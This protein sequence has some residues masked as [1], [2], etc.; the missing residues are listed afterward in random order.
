YE[1][2]TNGDSL[3]E[4]DS[5]YYVLTVNVGVQSYYDTNHNV[6]SD[7]GKIVVTKTS[8]VKYDETGAE[9]A[10]LSADAQIPFVNEDKEFTTTLPISANKTLVLAD[11][12][13]PVSTESSNLLGGMTF[14]F[15]FEEVNASSDSE[16]VTAAMNSSTKQMSVLYTNQTTATPGISHI[17]GTSNLDGTI[18]FAGEPF[19]SSADEF[20]TL[21]A[22][23]SNTH[24]Y[25][26]SERDNEYSA[27]DKDTNF[28]LVKVTDAMTTDTNGDPVLEASVDSI[29]K[30]SSTGTSLGTVSSMNEI[31]FV[32][33]MEDVE[34]SLNAT[35]HIIDESISR[36]KFSFYVF[37]E[38]A[39]T[40]DDFES[41]AKDLT[42]LNGN[43]T[44]CSTVTIDFSADNATEYL[45]KDK[46]A[47]LL[48]GKSL[49]VG[50]YDYYVWEDTTSSAGEDVISSVKTYAEDHT[51]YACTSD[52]EYISHIIWDYSYYNIHYSVVYDET[53]NK[54]VATP[55]ITKY[56]YGTDAFN[57]GTVVSTVEFTNNYIPKSGKSTVNYVIEKSL[58]QDGNTITNPDFT[59][60][61][62]DVTSIY[63]AGD[64]SAVASYTAYT[65]GGDQVTTKLS[66]GGAF[67]TLTYSPKDELEADDKNST[68]TYYYKIGEIAQDGFTLSK[69]TFYV[70]AVT[71][72][73]DTTYNPVDQES[74]QTE[75]VRRSASVIR[76][77]QTIT[78]YT[79]DDQGTWTNEDVTSSLNSITTEL[80]EDSEHAD[81]VTGVALTLD[82]LNFHNTSDEVSLNLH[83]RKYLDGL[84]EGTQLSY[85]SFTMTEVNG[86]SAS[87]SAVTAE[88]GHITGSSTVT[89]ANK[90]ANTSGI[91]SFDTI[92]FTYEDLDTID[93]NNPT[94]A[95]DY[96]FKIKEDVPTSKTTAYVYDDS[97]YIVTVRLYQ[98]TDGL[99]VPSLYE[100]KNYKSTTDN[101]PTVYQK[102]TDTD[103][104]T[105]FQFYNTTKKLKLSLNFAKTIIEGGA[106][107]QSARNGVD[108]YGDNEYYTYIMEKL[109]SAI[110]SA[111]G[112]FSPLSSYVGKK[113]GDSSKNR[114]NASFVLEYDLEDLPDYGH[115]VTYYYR[116]TE[117]EA[118][119]NG[120]D[121]LI[122]DEDE[123]IIAVKITRDS[124]GNL[125]CEVYNPVT[126][127]TY[128]LNGTY[129]AS[130]YNVQQNGTSLSTYESFT[131][132]KPVDSTI[133]FNATKMVNGIAAWKYG[134]LEF[135]FNLVKL[136]EVSDPT[137]GASSL[138]G[139]V[140]GSATISGSTNKNSGLLGFSNV[141][142]FTDASHDDYTVVASSTSTTVPAKAN[143][144]SY[145][146]YETTTDVSGITPDTSYYILTTYPFF[147]YNGS[148]TRIL[149]GTA[150]G[151]TALTTTPQGTLVKYTKN[152]SG[153]YTA[154]AGTVV[155]G[156]YYNDGSV[157]FN[158]STTSY[159]ASSGKMMLN[160][161]SDKYQLQLA[162]Q[163]Y[164]T[165]ADLSDYSG[166]FQIAVVEVDSHENVT[167]DFA[168]HYTITDG[169]GNHTFNL[170][171]YSA[172]DAGTHYYMVYEVVPQ[173]ASSD[174]TLKTI[175]F[176]LSY[177]IV[178]V[179]VAV[180]PYNGVVSVDDLRVTHKNVAYDD[181]V[182]DQ[183]LY[184][185]FVVTSSLA[186]TTDSSQGLTTGTIT[187]DPSTNTR[188]GGTTAASN[189]FEFENSLILESDEASISVSKTL[190][191]Y[192]DT[193]TSS[194][195][196]KASE[197]TTVDTTE[198]PMDEYTFAIERVVPVDES[199]GDFDMEPKTKVVG[200]QT[201]KFYDEVTLSDPTAQQVL[202]TIKYTK[203]D[204]ASNSATEATIYYKIFE[205]ADGTN[206][207]D[208][209]T[210]YDDS[211]YIWTVEL[212]RSGANITTSPT[213][214]KYVKD[215]NAYKKD[216]SSSTTTSDQTIV[217]NFINSTSVTELV[218]SAKKQLTGTTKATIADYE[219]EF[220]FTIT[221][222]KDDDA[223]VVTEEE[224]T[225]D[226]S[227]NITFPSLLY[228]SDDIGS[229]YHYVIAEKEGEDASIEYS[230][231]K[232]YVDVV[233][234]QNTSGEIVLTKNIYSDSAKTTSVEEAAMIFVNKKVPS[235]NLEL[236]K[237]IDGIQASTVE[238]DISFEVKNSDGETKTYQ[239]K[240]DFTKDADGVYHLLLANL[241][242]GAYVVTE[243]VTDASGA[244]ITQVGY[245]LNATESVVKEKSQDVDLT[246][247]AVDVT[248]EEE[249]TAS[250][251]FTNTYEEAEGELEITKTIVGDISLAS[252]ESTIYFLVKNN[253]TGDEV[254]YPLSEF[255][256]TA[257][258]AKVASLES[259]Y[260]TTDPE[261]IT[262]ETLKALVVKAQR[263]DSY[264]FTLSLDVSVGSYTVTEV[265]TAA[266]GKILQTIS[267]VLSTIK[268]DDTTVVADAVTD[269]VSK[270]TP[271]IV[272][273]VTKLSFTNTYVEEDES[274]DEEDDDDDDDPKT[275]DS[276]PLGL[277]IVLVVIS[278]LVLGYLGYAVFFG[279][280]KK[281]AEDE[282]SSK[283][284]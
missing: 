208:K 58:N 185:S 209:T 164:M 56:T 226:A 233:V 22:T 16:A 37:D 130:Y 214:T 122:F 87:A 135:D 94:G 140:L 173:N 2:D 97:F 85:F 276:T 235:G 120:R 277:L 154:D 36:A 157:L 169:Y 49:T 222:T 53:A 128:N 66:E 242:V 136:G 115:E 281:D 275:G 96:Y 6:N 25:K 161:L 218:L 31:S 245:S 134:N 23:S 131:N 100:V 246:N 45:V 210:Q 108:S 9:S 54:L 41:S 269:S 110:G 227:G 95:K 229:T 279:E 39:S 119:S 183:T 253:A 123:L 34:V 219:N 112:S 124:S 91:A 188:N 76:L 111:D 274:E 272:G 92:T 258:D 146:F 270:E 236:T 84:M 228:T 106:S 17:L 267:Y 216:T 247:T 144:V 65:I 198:I 153:N 163:K 244:V 137:L 237:T 150:Q 184:K 166:D 197:A 83:A 27:V 55:T 250:L 241:P 7:A 168:D 51:D 230:T 260:L 162:I 171:V 118:G 90:N 105:V 174:A 196:T 138:G 187:L 46:M 239:L 72:S 191:V 261:T 35:K 278:A 77:T 284:E 151:A 148:S 132:R 114:R 28:Y 190:Q 4:Y 102:P 101:A 180:N 192:T 126:L 30:Y 238:G 93:N 81:K 234:G 172:S 158:L 117:D 170:P 143:A 79:K 186:E 257:K 62:G 98:D 266:D 60:G 15:Y 89:S 78:K 67:P 223:T 71:L 231:Q 206:V 109:T 145:L 264:N 193:V 12:T 220:T 59:F 243:K 80:K 262:D 29:T 273:G 40:T 24:Y 88:N 57:G 189:G 215:G 147:Y 121:D 199:T 127:V 33:T 142:T 103:T 282:K 221:G 265:A 50:E 176:D 179:N 75:A 211:F 11:G 203:S 129:D 5:N 167:G 64:I 224:V 1:D 18:T 255:T 38:Q 47:T 113:D 86:D 52:E 10:T 125:S 195:T 43:K 42:N 240:D 26:I 116:I 21:T 159:S 280:K 212:T 252:A 48:S 70:A 156:T 194:G 182:T 149:Y 217:T 175:D 283:D 107:T 99:L 139:T 61:M 256:R 271:V 202:A 181:D 8:L 3:L 254:K 68:K 32:N 201:P 141:E 259:G 165:G 263:A 177:Y 69:D 225:N 104:S 251:D 213:V 152:S 155:S 249:E 13:T 160:N 268:A 82:A 204:F 19:Y 178:A 20:S 133:S 207:T 74:G 205:I 232:F 73:W 200:D 14:T 44:G 248:V 63:D